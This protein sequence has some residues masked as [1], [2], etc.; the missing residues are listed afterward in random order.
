M[1]VD[2]EALGGQWDFGQLGSLLVALGSVCLRGTLRVLRGLHCVMRYADDGL[3]FL[4]ARGWPGG[5]QEER[6]GAETR[7]GKEM[8]AMSH[9]HRIPVLRMQRG[10]LTWGEGCARWRRACH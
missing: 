4:V 8:R 7:H 5:K 9:L 2:V 3:F 10:W 1:H 6:D